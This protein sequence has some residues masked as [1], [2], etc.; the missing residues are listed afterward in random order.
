MPWSGGRGLHCPCSLCPWVVP[1][2]CGPAV[3]LL[4]RDTVLGQPLRGRHRPGG[5]TCRGTRMG[6]WGARPAP[7]RWGAARE[8]RPPPLTCAPPPAEV[9]PAAAGPVLLRRRGAE[10]G[11]RRAG[12]PGRAEGPAALH[13]ARQPVPL[14]PGEPGREGA[15]A[16]PA[17]LPRGDPVSRSP[18]GV[19]APPVG[20]VCWPRA[21]S[22][23]AWMKS[24]SAA[25]FFLRRF[26]FSLFL[27]W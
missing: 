25:S 17:P 24:C 11:G 20:Q 16:A 12:Q 19:A 27:L 1:S 5:L 21:L 13:A 4:H 23:F 22:A 18:A 8:R 3:W 2:G 6:G 10:P 7:R 9:R 26:S 15:G 14:L